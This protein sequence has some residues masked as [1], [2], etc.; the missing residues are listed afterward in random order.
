MAS[1]KGQAKRALL[2]HMS[3]DVFKIIFKG[4]DDGGINELCW[5]QGGRRSQSWRWA[6]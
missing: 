4:G 2:M 5:L 6:G 3:T 1:R